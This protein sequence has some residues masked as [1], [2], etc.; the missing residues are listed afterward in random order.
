LLP[1]VAV[2]NCESFEFVW[3][4]RRPAS[5]LFPSS[6][7]LCS[8]LRHG[9]FLFFSF[10]VW[11]AIF[12]GNTHQE[13]PHTPHPPTP[14]VHNG[15]P[16]PRM[17]DEE[18]MGD[19]SSSQRSDSD[20]DRTKNQFS[21]NL[22]QS[23]WQKN[24]PTRSWL[25]WTCRL[26]INA[27]SFENGHVI[28]FLYYPNP[29]HPYDYE[30]IIKYDVENIEGVAQVIHSMMQLSEGASSKEAQIQLCDSQSGAYMFEEPV[31][32]LW[33]FKDVDSDDVVPRLKS[34]LKTLLV[35]I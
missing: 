17:A 15:T 35:R 21:L 32:G 11:R 26:I 6:V 14:T 10:V 8:L 28:F 29:S 12:G 9:Y 7:Q 5:F 22:L 2:N 4:E 1:W 13:N 20:I 34:I 3:R 25:T 33:K 24:S 30:K 18:V 19:G 31:V 27:R 23:S 16:T